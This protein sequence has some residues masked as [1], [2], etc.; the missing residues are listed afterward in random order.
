MI[1]TALLLLRDL[2]E[3]RSLACSSHKRLA[4]ENLFLRKQL[5]FYVERKVKPRRLNNAARLTL[6]VLARVIDWQQLLMVV[7]PETLV[8]WHRQGF[9]LFWHWKSR[10]PGRP[11]I[12]LD[13]QN[14]IADMARANQTWGE[15]RIAAELLLKLGVAL[16][17]RTV[18]RYMRW[19]KPSRPGASSQ[20]W[21]TFVQNHA[22]E[23]LAC[24]FFVVVTATFRLVYVFVV[25]DI[26]TRRIVHWN[27]T[28]DPTSAWT[29]QQFRGV[30]TDEAPYRFVIHDRDAVFSP[31]VDDSLRSMDLGVLKTPVRMPQANTFCER[32]IGTARRECL[33]HLI[34]LHER[35]LRMILAE[36]VPHYNRGR[37]HA[38]LGPGIPE[39]PT[40]T[41]ARS[42]GHHI[43]QGC[44]VATKPILGG[45]HHEYRLEPAAA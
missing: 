4:A 18:R 25:M 22:R 14:L 45:L 23:T 32:L 9:R 12:P 13:L 41:A 38:S 6:V 21:N 16:S 20:A 35:H 30:L 8:R 26:G 43:P 36:W 33:D 37:P 39:P 27:L 1:R 5:A 3:F 24:D 2:L 15:E 28:E 42:V 31:A 19:P 40:A 34:P 11:R 29:V 10:R 7:R 17:P 44:R